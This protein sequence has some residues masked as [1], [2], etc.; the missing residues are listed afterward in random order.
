MGTFAE[1][2]FTDYQLSFANQGK[3]T[4]VSVFDF[5]FQQTNGS[6]PFL[7]TVCSKQTVVAVS[8][9]SVFCF[10]NFVL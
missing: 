2:A 10:T 1:K 8:V 9:T 6:L 5:R 7:I 4:S 3:Q